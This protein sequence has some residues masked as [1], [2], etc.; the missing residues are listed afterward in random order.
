M[1]H[2]HTDLVV[3]DKQDSLSGLFKVVIPSI[4]FMLLAA[5]LQ[6]YYVMNGYAAPTFLGKPFVLLSLLL[7]VLLSYLWFHN[8][9][10]KKGEFSVSSDSIGF[11]WGEPHSKFNFPLNEVENLTV[12]Y[13]GYSGFFSHTKGTENQLQF[14]HKGKNY[15]LN[16]LLKDEE[17]ASDMAKVLKTWYD[18]GVSFKEINTNGEERYLMLYSERYREQKTAIA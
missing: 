16:F 14:R 10:E 7:P 3:P 1:A 9:Y 13:D 4:L 12:V 6:S 2:F 8:N 15:A 18:N 17:A 11:E 5:F